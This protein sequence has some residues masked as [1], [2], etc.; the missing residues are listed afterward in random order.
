M[1][2][3]FEY[4]RRMQV[5]PRDLLAACHA[6]SIAPKAATPADLRRAFDHLMQGKQPARP[7]G[8]ALDGPI[9]QR[10]EGPGVTFLVDDVQPAD[11]APGTIAAADYVRSRLPARLI[12]TSVSGDLL[13]VDPDLNPLVM[14]IYTA[15]AEHRPLVLDPDS[16]WL[17]LAQGFAN[18]VELNADVLR[19]RFVAFKGRRALKAAIPSLNA[20]V[21]PGFVEHITADM[22]Q[23]LGPGLRNLLLCDFSTTTPAART[24][25]AVVM[26]AAF[27]RY[28][29]YVAV[30]ICGL[31]RVTLLG[32]PEDWRTI[33]TR[34][35]L[36][37]EYGLAHWTDRLGP[38]LEGLVRTAEGAPPLDF[39]QSICKPEQAYGAERITGWLADL[40]PYLRAHGDSSATLP[41]QRLALPRNAATAVGFTTAEFPRGCTH[42]PVKLQDPSGES[43]GMVVLHGGLM[44]VRVD[45]S[46]LTPCPGWAVAEPDPS[47]AAIARLRAHHTPTP[48]PGEPAHCWFEAPAVMIRIYTELGPGLLWEGQPHALT[49]LPK[50]VHDIR[51]ATLAD[52][53]SLH[54]QLHHQTRR[55]LVVIG[56]SRPDEGEDGIMVLGCP[57]FEPGT[58]RVVSTDP[59][60]FLEALSHTTD[61]FFFDAPGFEP[62][63]ALPPDL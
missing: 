14:A 10:V 45:E 11:V 59:D 46:G 21:W 37:S 38:I 63:C 44:G 19:S 2:A 15:F 9:A 40:F 33:A 35:A 52:G 49:L 47:T 23:D 13:R 51:F 5:E 6:L 36:F 57:A 60:A 58:A 39:W 4:A 48:R 8:F 26:M 20:E 55:W 28:Y 16:V 34:A 30:A 24:A 41:N 50:P 31:P 22:T 61:H 53:R 17:T 27:R 25:S 18:H 42:A 29:D 1:K 7:R 54:F 12:C 32:T 43:L 62:P 3:L 56:R